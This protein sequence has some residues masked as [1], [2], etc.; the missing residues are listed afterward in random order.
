[1]PARVVVVHDEP[2]FVNELVAA[3][4]LAGH[5][6]AVFADALAAWDAL[7]AA[8]LTEVL[9]TRAQFPPGR[10]NGLALTHMARAK[11]PGIQVI[12]TALPEF[13]RECESEGVFLPLPVPV[14]HA[15]KTVEL[16]LQRAPNSH[17][18]AA[19]ASLNLS[20]EGNGQPGTEP[21][22]G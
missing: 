1:M 12:F 20:G 8:R 6:V 18:K 7:A 10:S 19:G 13:R 5:E 16:L 14:A 3:L 4:K 2:G 9:I 11:R 15:V 17:A 22:L 21:S